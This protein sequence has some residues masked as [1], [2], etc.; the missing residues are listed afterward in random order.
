MKDADL[1]HLD[2]FSHE[3]NINF[4][5]FGPLMLNWISGQVD[6][7]DVVTINKCSAL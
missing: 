1:A 4:Y 3:M 7:T 6:S 2:L 5:V